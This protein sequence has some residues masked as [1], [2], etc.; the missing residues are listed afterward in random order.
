[1]DKYFYFAAQLPMLSF[2]NLEEVPTKDFFLEEASKWLSKTDLDVLNSVNIELF[3]TD[4][5]SMILR[6]CCA[7][8][9]ELRQELTKYRKSQKEDFEYKSNFF[10]M[11]LVKEGSPLDAEKKLLLFRWEFLE[12][13]QLGHYSDLDYLII[14]YMKLQMLW[15]L[16]SFNKE[17]GLESFK[18]LCVLGAV[19]AEE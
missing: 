4:K 6:E 3:K 9:Y 17:H 10:P 19:G 14:Y 16:M 8:E 2:D 5:K 11:S 18:N 7:F 13:K 1:M 15:R 12:E